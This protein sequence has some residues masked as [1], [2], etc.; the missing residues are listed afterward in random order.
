MRLRR[1]GVTG[2][3]CDAGQIL[4]LAEPAT[5]PERRHEPR[6]QRQRRPALDL[7]PGPGARA[8]RFRINLFRQQRGL[9]AAIRLVRSECR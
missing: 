1:Y 9:A 8:L 7:S 3:T 2:L 4:A 6:A 5:T